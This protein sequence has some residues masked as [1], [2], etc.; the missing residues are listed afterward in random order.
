LGTAAGTELLL[1]LFDSVITFR[2]RY[3]QHEDLLALT[4]VLVLDSSNPRAL[5]GVLRR[6]RTELSKLPGS[7]DSLAPLLAALP[8][9]GAG[10]TLDALRGL[11]DQQVAQTLHSLGLRLAATAA[12]LAEAV[13]GRF[14]TLADGADQRV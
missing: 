6:L 14:F 3:Q 8:A 11:D 9:Q 7:A 5:A 1:D 13:S 2:A 4:D 12:E 10:L